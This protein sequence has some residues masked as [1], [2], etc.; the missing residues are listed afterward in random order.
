MGQRVGKTS[1]SNFHI[2]VHLKRP[3]CM[4]PQPFRSKCVF[5]ANVIVS[6]LP[7][8]H[9]QFRGFCQPI[10]AKKW[11]FCIYFTVNLLL[12]SFSLACTRSILISIYQSRNKVRCYRYDKCICNNWKNSNAFKNSIP[13]SCSNRSETL[14]SHTIAVVVCKQWEKLIFNDPFSFQILLNVE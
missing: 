10:L 8:P 6:L 3:A 13:N 5:F 4:I 1:N 12:S 14:D 9:I 2:G 7:L 11:E